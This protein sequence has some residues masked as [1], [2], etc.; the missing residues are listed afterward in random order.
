MSNGYLYRCCAPIT[1]EE[2][3]KLLKQQTG[4]PAWRLQEQID[5]LEF[6]QADASWLEGLPTGLWPQ[7]RV[8]GPNTEVRW[9]MTD[10][11]NLDVLV[12]SETRLGLSDEEWYEQQMEVRRGYGLYLWGERK[13][14]DP[15]WIETRIPR[16]LHYPVDEQEWQQHPLPYV[17]VVARDYAEN[18]I[19]RLTRLVRVEPTDLPQG[20]RDG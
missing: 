20:G 1:P 3:A 17:K 10:D 4:S 16:P 15:Y 12:L 7:G 5:G 18:G 2:L 13:P 6:E 8:F 14:D 9:W 11:G 19:V